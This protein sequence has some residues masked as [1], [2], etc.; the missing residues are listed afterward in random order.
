[1]VN[2]YLED[3]N[4]TSK[5][6]RGHFANFEI[7]KKLKNK[8]TP[9]EEKDRQ[10]V[11]NDAA[12]GTAIKVGHGYATLKKHYMLPELEEKYVHGGKIINLTNLQ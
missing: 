4:I 11:L 6:I 2:R 5:D 12:R 10:K 9:K 7:I 1:M 8:T 3:Y